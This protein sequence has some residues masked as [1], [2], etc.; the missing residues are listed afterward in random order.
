MGLFTAIGTAL[1]PAEFLSSTPPRG[2]VSKIFQKFHVLPERLMIVYSTNDSIRTP[3][4]PLSTK[5]HSK[6]V[7][8][9]ILSRAC[10]IE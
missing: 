5:S 8:L 2:P 3:N 1:A 9:F 10:R 4:S 7:K 6:R